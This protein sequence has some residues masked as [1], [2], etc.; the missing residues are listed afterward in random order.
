MAS[1]QQVID[2]HSSHPDWSADEIARELKCGAA[3]VRATARRNRLKLADRRHD[4]PGRR[5]QRLVPPV[6]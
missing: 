4:N 1:K 3:Y 6:K 2:A 5:P